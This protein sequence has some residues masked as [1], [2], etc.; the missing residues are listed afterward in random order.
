MSN[1]QS[2]VQALRLESVCRAY[3]GFIWMYR[4][5]DALLSLKEA[6]SK[7]QKAVDLMVAKNPVLSGTLAQKKDASEQVTIDYKSNLE[8]VSTV[9][10]SPVKVSL[11][12]KLVEKSG[13]D[14]NGFPELFGHL[15]CLTPDIEGLPV[16]RLSIFGFECGSLAVA[17]LCHHILMD[18]RAAIMV[19]EGIARACCCYEEKGECLELWHDRNVI[20]KLLQEHAL[21]VSAKPSDVCQH[22]DDII[23][24]SSESN[25]EGLLQAIIATEAKNKDCQFRINKSKI[26]RLKSLPNLDRSIAGLSANDLVMALLWRTWSRILVTLGSSFPGYT[27]TGGPIDMRE[28]LNGH[29]SSNTSEYLGNM[30]LPHPI[31]ATK[32]FVVQQPLLSVALLLNQHKRRASVLLYKEFAER[33]ESG[34]PDI[35]ATVAVSDSPVI[36][37]SNMTRLPIYSVDFNLDPAKNKADSVQ[38]CSFESPLMAF[39]VDDGAGG[40]LINIVLPEIVAQA[41]ADDLEFTEYADIIY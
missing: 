32:E 24:R 2:S 30:V 23:A 25:S 29:T 3:I 35:L 14:Q 13:F 20:R 10:V 5:T 6:V 4:H 15:K 39:A 28:K 7:V 9:P 37:F 33:V 40:F 22:M 16:L 27:Y 1:T 31:S 26:A 12:Y 21:S 18:A 38:L 8:S 36:T 41:F 34:A 17:V 11:R 19:A